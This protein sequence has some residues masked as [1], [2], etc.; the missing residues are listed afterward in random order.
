[1][2]LKV[3][4]TELLYID[5]LNTYK[6]EYENLSLFDSNTELYLLGKQ[7]GL[8]I[9]VEEK[10]VGIIAIDK[11]YIHCL[12]IKPEYRRKGIAKKIIQELKQG[13]TLRGNS[14]PEAFEFWLA[15]GAKFKIGKKEMKQYKLK[16]Y[17]AEF[18]L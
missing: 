7:Y 2:L 15:L 4:D 10:L 14:L 12:E 16:G 3:F 11:D 6:Q 8:G 1:M 18:E 13:K 5:Y 17:T 9:Y